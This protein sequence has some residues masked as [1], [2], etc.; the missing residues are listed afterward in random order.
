MA[1]SPKSYSA[2]LKLLGEN[3]RRTDLVL[4]RLRREIVLILSVSLRRK[5][6]LGRYQRRDAAAPQGSPRA[7]RFQVVER[8]AAGPHLRDS[9]GTCSDAKRSTQVSTPEQSTRTSI[10]SLRLPIPPHSSCRGAFEIAF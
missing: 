6:L 8:E 7:S 2:V 4:R 3:L 5:K 9:H 1:V 10:R